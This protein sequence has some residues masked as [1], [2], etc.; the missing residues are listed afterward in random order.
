MPNE[1]NF[2]IKT[3]KSKRKTRKNTKK[4]KKNLEKRVRKDND[5]EIVVGIWSN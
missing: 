2:N 4:S 3:R 5:E 1:F